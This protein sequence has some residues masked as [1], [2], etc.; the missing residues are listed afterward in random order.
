MNFKTIAFG[1][2]DGVARIVLNRPDKLNSLD[3]T[4]QRELGDA[5]LS[6]QTDPG[7]RCVLITGAGRAFCAGQDLGDGEEASISLDV[8]AVL[9]KY[10]NPL[11]KAITGMDKPVICAVNG[12]AAGAGANIALACDIVLAAKSA[13]FIQA[14]SKIGLVPDAGGTWVLPRLIGHARASAIT[15]LGE[16]ISAAK[17][18]DWG[19][20]WKCVD[21]ED[22]QS[23]CD[24]LALHLARQ[25]TTGL[26]YTKKLLQLGW[27]NSLPRQ[28]ELEAEFQR[29]AASTQDFREG[30]DAFRHKRQANFTGR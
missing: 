29:A 4:M 21:D 22:L 12:V 19:M 14:F 8:G 13:S 16:K 30:V 17:A 26:A 1:K 5:V 27:Q 11:I 2:S 25:A 15:L 7:V 23:T 6:T 20:I 9:E 10:Y 18:E 3:E 28:L 24:E